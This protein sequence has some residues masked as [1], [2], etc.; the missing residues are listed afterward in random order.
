M[1]RE[2]AVEEMDQRLDFLLV[3]RAPLQPLHRLGISLQASVF[4]VL[5]PLA[6]RAGRGVKSAGGAKS[7]HLGESNPIPV[8]HGR[9]LDYAGQ[10]DAGSDGEFS[11]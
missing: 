2:G 11:V 10:R 8:E 4:V 7:P 1:L 9:N 3:P 6:L 5:D